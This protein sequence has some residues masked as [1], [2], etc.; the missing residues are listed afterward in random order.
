M[1]RGCNRFAET[2]DR[3]LKRG[4]HFRDDYPEKDPAAATYNN[5]VRRGADGAMIL[6]RA[7]IPPLPAELQAIIEE[8]KS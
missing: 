3:K 1:P 6:Q 4:G 8:M 2:I 5:I 7:A